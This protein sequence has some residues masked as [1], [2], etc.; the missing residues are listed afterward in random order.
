MKKTSLCFAA[1]FAVLFGFFV[2]SCSGGADSPNLTLYMQ[3]SGGSS[4][5]GGGTQS[6]TNP[7]GPG[8]QDPAAQQPEPV[9]CSVTFV[10]NNEAAT[11]T[12][13]AM[14]GLKDSSITLTAN[15][16]SLDGYVFTGWNTKSDGSGVGY[17]D[18]SNLKLEEN[19]TLYAQWLLATVPT[20]EIEV[21][22]AENGIVSA[23]AQFAAAGSIV[24]IN[25]SPNDEYEIDTLAVTAESGNAVGAIADANNNKVYSFTMPEE[26]VCVSAAFKLKKYT[27]TFV[28]GCSTQISAKIVESGQKVSAATLQDIASECSGFDG[29][30][31]ANDL[32]N[33]FDFNSPIKQDVVLYAK[34]NIFYVTRK[35]IIE[36]INSLRFSAC[37]HI[38]K[39]DEAFGDTWSSDFIR[40][41][42]NAIRKLR[43][44]VKVALDFKDC[45]ISL[46][47]S[48][49][50]QYGTAAFQDCKQLEGVYLP[51]KITSIGMSAFAGCGLKNIYIPYG[52]TQ[53]QEGVFWQCSLKKLEIPDSV[54]KISKGAFYGC[55]LEELTIP[56]VGTEPKVGSPVYANHLFGFAFSEGDAN[57]RQYYSSS[58]SYDCNIPKTLKKVTVTGGELLYGAFSGCDSIEEI[59]LK[60]GVTSI[61]EA[62]FM[63]CTSLKNVNIPSG[64][65]NISANTFKGCSSLESI[66]IPNTVTSIGENA[67]MGCSSL[68]SIEIPSSV[69]SIGENAFKGCSS[70]KNMEIP[71][72]V[73]SIGNNPFM[74][75]DSLASLTIS[76]NITNTD[77]HIFEGCNS[78]KKVIIQGGVT[79]IRSGFLYGCSSLEELTIPFVGWRKTNS[80]SSYE[81]TLFG[82]IFGKEEY[83][84]SVCV[85]QWYSYN[86]GTDS[87]FSMFYI[88]SSLRKVVVTGGKL[89]Y[90][91]FYGCNFI[92][93]VE[94][95]E[96]VTSIGDYAFY[97]C[98]SLKN[99]DLPSNITNLGN[100]L[101]SGCSSLESVN[102]PSSVTEIGG[103][104]F[105]GC[106]SLVS[107]NIPSGVT[108]IENAVFSG[109]SSLAS[110]TVPSGVTTIGNSAF[111]DCS[112]LKNINIPSGVTKIN[113][114]TFNGCSEL[115]NISIP[116][117]VTEIG[118]DAFNGCR[119]L[120]S[121]KIPSGVTTI[122]T[123]TFKDCSSLI[124]V[125]IPSTVNIIGRYA[126]Y[127]C[128]S[129]AG[130]EIPS[131]VTS[132]NDYVFS[133]CSSLVSV[134]IPSGVTSIGSSA[135]YD[136][137]SLKNINIPSGVTSIGSSSFAFCKK[138]EIENLEIPSGVTS[139]GG[140]AFI[141][142]NL[143]KA[144]TIPA[145][146]KRIG[147]GAF[148]SDGIK[149]LFFEDTSS[150]WYRTENF[151]YTGGTEFGPMSGTPEENLTAI[152]ETYKNSHGLDVGYYWYVE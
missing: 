24:T 56:F 53:I 87:S 81:T 91:A 57:V 15:G 113:E 4:D 48:Y 84:G 35:T 150:V 33:K 25:L 30:Y 32:A 31:A 28:T 139:I 37:L 96:G 142:C 125:E 63:G 64:I 2:A 58:S 36:K 8:T 29:W 51:K 115:E 119:S 135:F 20:Y 112:S 42:G 100:S 102:I 80:N 43:N 18:C 74:G 129:L 3:P 151:K 22:S 147:S 46:D 83:S 127:G 1:V 65:T 16:F 106:S 136:C 90:G 110:I 11:G 54:T 109:C 124:S 94:L 76:S 88:P 99:I 69:T 92:E 17:A 140:C 5:S 71:S 50:V 85:G 149:K 40:E 19:L 67:F 107:V 70:L 66:T 138:L 95:K 143:I 55:P 121:V 123:R 141:G 103:T 108:S 137:S 75:C 118:V 7:T 86:N 78:L 68:K 9:Y 39:A 152:N 148:D 23:S 60:D 72:S 114:K 45:D 117:G 6:P 14:T 128:S 61:G 73:T 44:E 12:M 101:F 126:F 79:Y 133:R 59:V 130:V 105:S 122:T 52:V 27:V 132:I 146:V 82:Y 49:K 131:G 89:L 144:V 77:A 38:L 41:V 10:A 98:A 116:S 104:A 111:S 34:W 26:K 93:S 134:N 97:G 62:A 13:A 21:A 145:S 120:K 47:L